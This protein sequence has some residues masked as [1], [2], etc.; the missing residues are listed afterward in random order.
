MAGMERPRRTLTR[1]RRAAVRPMPINRG[2]RFGGRDWRRRAAGSI[3]A[4]AAAGSPE[5]EG[6]SREPDGP[7]PARSVFSQF[8]PSGQWWWTGGGA[9]STARPWVPTKKGDD[10]LLTCRVLGG[11]SALF[12]HRGFRPS[13]RGTG[14]RKNAEPPA[15]RRP[16]AA[17]ARRRRPPRALLGRRPE[18]SVRWLVNGV[19]VDEEYEHNTG[20][21]IE[22]RLLWPALRR[23][24]YAAVFTCQA[25]NSDLVQPR[26]LSLVLD[27]FL[28]PLTVQIRRAGAAGGAGGAGEAGEGGA[29]TAD[30]RYELT[31][32]SA[33]SRPPALITWHKGKRQLKRITVSFRREPFYVLKILT[34][35]YKQFIGA[36]RG[37]RDGDAIS[38]PTGNA[39]ANSQHHGYH[40]SIPEQ[41]KCI[42]VSREG[43]HAVAQ[44][45]ITGCR[46]PR[47]QRLQTGT[48]PG[49]AK[50]YVTRAFRRPGT[51][52]ADH[53]LAPTDLRADLPPWT[54]GGRSK[55]PFALELTRK[56]F[57]PGACCS[58]R[59]RILSGRG[60]YDAELC[61]RPRNV[62]LERRR[63]RAAPRREIEGL[64][65]I[66][67]SCAGLVFYL[68]VERA[69][70][71][72]PFRC[73]SGTKQ[74]DR[75]PTQSDRRRHRELRQP[76][77]ETASILSTGYQNSR[78]RRCAAGGRPKRIDVT[79]NFS[80]GLHR[81]QGLRPRTLHLSKNS[82]ID[83]STIS[84]IRLDVLSEAPSA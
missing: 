55:E 36:P 12:N 34:I 62:L 82:V 33:G 11:P 7:R 14:P 70:P 41:I 68:F 67:D 5:T 78:D 79:I 19:P 57:I 15:P 6:Q 3:N 44:N 61:T 45:Q 18:P 38:G 17:R 22:N 10:V 9:L 54:R 25:A 71:T 30:R 69:R 27:M 83:A 42:F 72:R 81:V 16:P 65:L 77:R 21:V 60:G 4:A 49:D 50:T 76:A 56:I 1:S 58:L 43:H 51:K 39:L 35:F 47:P 8:P 48:R 13:V 63:G 84:Q 59:R 74:I 75:R 52:G 23:A 64:S 32:D 26:E 24:D 28:R 53:F 80:S 40:E 46:H 73:D 31:C 20:D 29:L 37:N 2:R 66:H